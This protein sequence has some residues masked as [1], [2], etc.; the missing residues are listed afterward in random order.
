MKTTCEWGRIDCANL[1]ESAC[2]FC[3]SDSF[4]YVAKKVYKPMRKKAVSQ[5][6][7]MGSK[8]EFQNHLN[9]EALVSTRLT[10]NSG[11]TAKE[12]GDEQISGII[13]V[14]EEL[15]TQMPDRAKGTLSFAIKRKWLEK[16]NIEAR[17]EDKEFWYLKFRFAEDE[18]N[19]YVVVEEDII[20]SMVK[21]MIE[22]RKKA[23]LCDS[24]INYISKRYDAELARRIS[25]ETELNEL[26]SKINLAKLNNDI[27]NIFTK[28]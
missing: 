28:L 8:F 3:I 16:L 2:D 11:A 15:K 9:N 23:K 14:M 26:K 5:D 21:T 18:K 13:E 22:D 17:K 7:R 6:K 27:D 12:K 1:G 20:M 19:T 4:N 25:L 24:K 10:L